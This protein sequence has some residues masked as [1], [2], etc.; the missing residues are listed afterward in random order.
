MKRREFLEKTLG[1][2]PDKAPP[3]F[4][5]TTFEKWADGEGLVRDPDDGEQEPERGLLAH[6]ARLR[7]QVNRPAPMTAAG[8]MRSDSQ[9]IRSC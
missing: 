5:G 7:H 9:V 8:I 1:T 2:H 3:D 4:A 6:Y